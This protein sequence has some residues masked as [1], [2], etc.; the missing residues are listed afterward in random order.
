MGHFR[1]NGS[2]SVFVTT[3]AFY[4]F[5]GYVSLA[6]LHTEVLGNVSLDTLKGALW[7]LH[8]VD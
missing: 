6:P 7:K 4:F 8:K 1:R 2:R 3:L 5:P